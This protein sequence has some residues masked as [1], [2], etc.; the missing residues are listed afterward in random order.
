[1]SYLHLVTLIVSEYDAAIDYFV[2]VLEFELIE[3]SPAVTND[4]R[5]KRWV[6]VR[7]RGGQTGFLLARA[8]GPEQEAQVGNQM[9]GRV[10]FFLRVD[11]FRA[12]LER[13]K[14]RGVT[15]L[16]EPRQEAY[17]WVAVFA[18]LYGNK[19]DL[20]GD[21]ER[22][23]VP[24]ELTGRCLCEGV[25]YRIEGSLGPIFH[26]HC[27]KCRRWHGSAYRTRASVEKSRFH[28][29]QG[30]ELLSRY[31]SSENV[32]KSF[33]SRCGSSLISTYRNRPD[34]VGVPLGGLEQDPQSR[35]EAHIF[36]NSKSPWHEITDGLPQFPEWPGGEERVRQTGD[37]SAR[38]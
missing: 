33:C 24:P 36:V 12:S 7:P 18:D 26:C 23:P 27:S 35:P 30:E 9:A 3:D 4:G 6:V 14:T 5:A 37:R 31:E 21:L 38:S 15:F 8:D 10:G 28:W 22:A 29:V 19:W 16:T 13:M 17:G 1:M 20:L 34:I 2:T 11:D 25:V 32:T